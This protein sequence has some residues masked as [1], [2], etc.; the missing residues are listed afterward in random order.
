MKCLFWNI[1]GI[2]NTP[3]KLALRKLVNVHN[4]NIV[5]ITEPWMD[6]SDFPTRW[7]QRLGLKL[8]CMNDRDN[9]IPNIWCICKST[10]EPQ[11]LL[12]DKQCV[13]FSLLV[14][15]KLIG[16]AAVYASNCY[17][18]RRILWS[19]LTSLNNNHAIPWC[20]LGDFNVVLG[21]HGYKGNSLP[22][23]LPMSEFQKW[24]NSNNLLHLPTIGALFTWANG[25]RG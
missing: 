4:P 5:V 1:R 17:I 15:D 12:I 24:T 9:L 25:R 7:L 10:L 14:Q 8:F 18:N 20:F 11:V 22:A 23:S 2:A 6:F 16:F 13:A 21:I 3:S 19:K